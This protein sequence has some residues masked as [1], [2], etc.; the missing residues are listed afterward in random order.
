MIYGFED[1]DFW[2]AL[3]CKGWHGVRVDEPLFCYRK[4]A[5][6]S[7]LTRTQER[8][9]EMIQRMVEHHRWLYE[10]IAPYAITEKDRLFFREHMELWQLREHV[11]RLQSTAGPAPFDEPTSHAHAHPAQ[12][13]LLSIEQ[14]FAW[15]TVQRLKDNPIYDAVARARWGSQWKMLDAKESPQQR[16]ERIKN[17]RSY[18][19]IV[20]IKQTGVYKRYAKMKYGG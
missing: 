19:M 6:G 16:L 12:R 3:L 7:M 15:R 1:W 18:R 4:H 17:S 8:R 10:R 5:T 13:E 14:S 20:A 9:G 2:L 11:A